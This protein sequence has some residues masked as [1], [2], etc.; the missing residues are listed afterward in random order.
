VIFDYNHSTVYAN[1]VLAIAEKIGMKK[2]SRH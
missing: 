1:T 2:V